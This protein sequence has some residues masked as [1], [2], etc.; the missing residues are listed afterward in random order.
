MKSKL[1]LVVI[2]N[3]FLLVVMLM[4]STN[5]GWTHLID[6]IFVSLIVS[7]IGVTSGFIYLFWHS[8]RTQPLGVAV[9]SNAL[10]G[11]LVLSWIGAFCYMLLYFVG[12]AI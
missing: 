6:I 1:Q 10:P 11:V 3:F 9:R 12:P 5:T 4:K 8:I 2:V 7:T